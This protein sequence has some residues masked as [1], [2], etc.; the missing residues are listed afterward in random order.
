MQAIVSILTIVWIAMVVIAGI[1]LI[2]G[3][4]DWARLHGRKAAGVLLAASLPVLV[5]IGL[6]APKDS[7]KTTTP[8]ISHIPVTTES[9]TATSAASASTAPTATTAV[10]TT[11]ANVPFQPP[12]SPPPP[13]T[14]P[15]PAPAPAFVPAPAGAEPPAAPPSEVYY[16]NCAAARAAG[17]APILRGQPGYRPGLD[18]DNDGIACE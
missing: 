5:L 18:R 4:L 10:T 13:S 7:G 6:L 17:A 9:A 14:V 3:H 11:T 1:G 15:A 16:P 12:A 8:A 2:R